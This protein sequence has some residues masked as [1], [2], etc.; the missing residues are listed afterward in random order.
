MSVRRAVLW[1]VIALSLCIVTTA[2]S[3]PILNPKTYRSP[4]GRY[5]LFVDPSKMDGSGPASYRFTHDNEVIWEGERPY[6][7]WD[8]RVTNRGGVGGYAYERGVHTGNHGTGYNGLAVIM[9]AP[10]GSKLI[11][12][13]PSDTKH[14][15]EKNGWAGSDSAGVLGLLVDEATDRFVVRV[16]LA[17]RGSSTAWWTYRLSTGELIGEVLPAHPEDPKFGF[18]RVVFAEIVPSTPLTL[19]HWY[20]YQSDGGGAS[21]TLVDPDGK[22]V[23]SFDLPGEYDGLKERWSWYWDMV[24]PGIEQASVEPGAFAFRSYSESARLSYRVQPD[25]QSE[26]G[27]RVVELERAPDRLPVGHEAR[28]HDQTTPIE[29]EFLGSIELAST[30]ATMHPIEQVTKFGIEPSGNLGFVRWNG[31]RTVRFVRVDPEGEIL[32]NVV[33]DLPEDEDATLPRVTPVSDD[34]WVLLRPTHS[35]TLNGGAYWMDAKTGALDQ[36]E[37]FELSGIASL[38]PCADGGF[39]VLARYHGN[40]TIQDG[41]RRFDAEGK[42]DWESIRPEFARGMSLQAAT[43][44][45]DQR[46]AVLT[47]TIKTLEFLDADGTHERSVELKDILTHRPNYPTGL[48]PDPDGGLILHDFGARLPISRISPSGEVTAS[49]R[50]RFPDGRTFTL[51]ADVQAAPDGTMWTTD[52]HSLLRLDEQGVV[53]R[54]IGRKPQDNALEKVRAL[55]VDH[56]GRIYAVNARTAAVH[57]FE[58]DGTPLR[59]CTPDPED[60]ATKGGGIGSITVDGEGTIYYRTDTMSMS[61]SASYLAISQTGERIGFQPLN[62]HEV[63]RQLLCMPASKGR[64]VLGY[65]S[66]FVVDEDGDIAKQVQR[67]PDGSW[68]AG[69]QNGAVALDG[70]LAVIATPSGMMGGRGPAVMCTYQADGTPMGAFTLQGQSIFARVAFTASTII[71]ADGDAVYLYDPDGGN[72]RK[73]HPPRQDGENWWRPYLTPDGSE[74]LLQNSGATTLLRYRMP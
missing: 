12:G 26:S 1:A 43:V 55:T 16:P 49:F 70:S 60:F 51:S 38:V 36:I 6:S 15:V 35:K 17:G 68:L 31:D 29:L 72:P 23:W 21:L 34:R 32:T 61:G 56:E 44:L 30:D 52:G 25:Q 59:I 65:E 19:M 7:L 40:Y 50:P 18:L 63:R 58:P 9:L 41:L 64:W 5:S 53:D 8:A 54:V 48:A 69:V 10:D 20:D 4:S 33:L 2:N 74:L 37:D 14:E 39:L 73:F 47:G 57:M 27:W 13:L 45:P 46:V 11:H 24:E 22:L 71:T 3:D 62:I 42:L 28:E 66:V 67:R